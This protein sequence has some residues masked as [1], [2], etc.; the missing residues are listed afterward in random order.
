MSAAPGPTNDGFTMIGRPPVRANLVL[1]VILSGILATI[2]GWG[3]GSIIDSVFDVALAPI[4]TIPFCFLLTAGICLSYL[5]PPSAR[6]V[7]TPFAAQPSSA[8]RRSRSA[9]S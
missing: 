7:S 2:V 3:L 4:I 6:S 5:R 8:A 9:R 1:I